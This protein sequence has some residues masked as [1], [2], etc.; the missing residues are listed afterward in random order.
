LGSCLLME[1]GGAAI[2]GSRLSADCGSGGSAVTQQLSGQRGRGW[3]ARQ[4]AQKPARGPSFDT[5]NGVRSIVNALPNLVHTRW[6]LVESGCGA[7]VLGRPCRLP[8]R[9]PCRSSGCRRPRRLPVW[10]RPALRVRQDEEQAR[11]EQPQRSLD[12]RSMLDL[13]IHL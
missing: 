1:I 11:R 4:I 6:G 13:G 8:P 7:V 5:I 2:A 3:A 10:Q 9:A 12:A